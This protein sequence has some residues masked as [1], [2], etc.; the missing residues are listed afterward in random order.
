[1]RICGGGKWPFDCA[2]WAVSNGRLSSFGLLIRCI[3]VVVIISGSREFRLRKNNF[4]F[5]VGRLGRMRRI[6]FCNTNDDYCNSSEICNM[7]RSDIYQAQHTIYI[8]EWDGL[9]KEKNLIKPSKIINL[10]FTVWLEFV[11]WRRNGTQ[12]KTPS[13]PTKSVFLSPL[14]CVC[15]SRS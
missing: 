4:V 2:I 3:V 10:H 6:H 9:W 14:F 15:L 7:R 13:G 12:H 11:C 1:M 5:S 8:W